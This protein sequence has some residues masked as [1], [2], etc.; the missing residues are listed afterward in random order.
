MPARA[1]GGAGGRRELAVSP[2]LWPW[3]VWYIGGAVIY[4]ALGGS[5]VGASLGIR[6]GQSKRGITW[7]LVLGLLLGGIGGG[8]FFFLDL[9]RRGIM[10]TH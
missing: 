7:G 10:P 9:R 2:N 5:A 8:I 4:G 6:R 1:A 3:I